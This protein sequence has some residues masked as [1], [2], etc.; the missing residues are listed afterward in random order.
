MF[1]ISF[2][3]TSILKKLVVPLFIFSFLLLL[4]VPLIGVEVKG[5]KRWLNLYL[6]KIQPIEILKPFFILASAKILTLEKF[7]NS[8]LKY[9][10]SFFL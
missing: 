8:Q 10:L 1:S 3:E 6:L 2:I 9:L 4:L 7:Q 5:S